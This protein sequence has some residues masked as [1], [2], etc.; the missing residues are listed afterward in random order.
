MVGMDGSWCPSCGYSVQPGTQFCGSCGQQL[1]APVGAAP[2][3]PPAGTTHTPAMGQQFLSAPPPSGGP[4][5]PPPSAGTRSGWP[6]PPPPSSQQPG[7]PGSPG[8]PQLSDT[9]ERML[10][11]QGLFQ[12]P[13]PKQYDWN[14]QWTPGA[15]TASTGPTPVTGAM[16]MPPAGPPAA[17]GPYPPGGYPT[18]AFNQAG[19]PTPPPPPGYPAGGPATTIDRYQPGPGSYPPGPPY[20]GAQ[21]Q[22]PPGQHPSGPQPGPYGQPGQPG[23]PP[24]GPYN[25]GQFGPGQVAPGQYGVDQYGATQVVQPYPGATGAS[26]APTGAYGLPPAGYG[27]GGGFG[28]DGAFGPDGEPADGQKPPW[29][30]FDGKVTIPRKPLILAIAGVAA[31]VVIIV[32]YVALSGS[33][34]GSSGNTPA[35]ASGNSASSTAKPSAGG[36][37]ATEK[38]AMAQLATLLK[39]S[40]SDHAAVTDAVTNVEACGKNLGA[41]AQTFTTS[42]ANRN[43]LLAKLAALPGRG[44]LP[45]AMLSDLNGAWQASASVDSDLAKWASHAATAGCH[46][47]DLNYSSYKASIADDTPATNGKESFV[48]LWNPLAK[49]DGLPTYQAAQL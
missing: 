20:T 34:S 48:A 5:P 14:S 47:G 15:A 25:G 42:A 41:D 21:P 40:G 8:D 46:G 45:T 23:Y 6:P 16:P 3:Q 4:T 17:G 32:A 7:G 13:Q 22:L 10:R 29:V 43:S 35:A 44:S 38:A 12:H 31:L 1:A 33:P 30:F 2:G 11:P 39:Q 24:Q 9:M 19:G 28:P 36:Q 49:Q 37:S 18:G 27:P 26:G